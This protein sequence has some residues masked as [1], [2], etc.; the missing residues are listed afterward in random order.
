MLAQA[1]LI[2]AREQYTQAREFAALDARSA[3]AALEEAEASWAASAG[4][5]EQANR[6]YTIAEVRYREGISTQ[7]ELTESRILL[8]QAQANR[9]FAARNLQVARV[10][11]SLLHDLPLG[12]G[13][14]NQNA[15]RQ[16]QRQQ[17]E[18]QQQQQ[19][20]PPQ[21]AGG[22]TQN[23]NSGGTLQ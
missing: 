20:Q 9:A 6:A 11:L 17:Q 22:F 14:A 8:Q 16:Q 10:R 1:D 5:A 23:A 2:E 12:N 13:N 18:Q 4:T 3:I 21:A 7:L 15:V 19:S